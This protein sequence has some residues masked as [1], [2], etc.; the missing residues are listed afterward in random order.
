ME[1]SSRTEL[2]PQYKPPL[3]LT[4]KTGENTEWTE[5]HLAEPQR[6]AA[7]VPI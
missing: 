3:V 1:L 4:G 5:V 2:D 7:E 6:E